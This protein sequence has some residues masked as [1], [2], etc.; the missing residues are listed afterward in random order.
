MSDAWRRRNPQIFA[1]FRTY[2]KAVDLR[3]VKEQ[4]ASKRHLLA[5]KLCHLR[6]FIS[7][8]KMSRL[9]KFRII[10]KESLWHHTKEPSVADGSRHIVEFSILFPRKPHKYQSILSFAE[11]QDLVQAFLCL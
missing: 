1:D 4:L 11:K 8:C 10:G 3:A 7:R 5:F 6:L 9:I 2:G